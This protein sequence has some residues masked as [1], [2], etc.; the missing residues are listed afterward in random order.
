MLHRSP[1]ANRS[2]EASEK[3]QTASLELVESGLAP[4]NLA[5][6]PVKRPLSVSSST[7]GATESF[8]DSFVG[9]D[10]ALSIRMTSLNGRNG[11]FS[12]GGGSSTGGGFVSS[13]PIQK[14]SSYSWVT[15]LLGCLC[16]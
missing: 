2:P 14:E 11:R 12:K 3:Q 9:G 16:G 15:I 5:S 6:S 4:V 7:G 10:N 13:G 8:M 1:G